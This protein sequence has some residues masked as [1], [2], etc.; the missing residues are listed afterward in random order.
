MYREGKRV[1]TPFVRISG[2]DI[3][4]IVESYRRVPRI[5]DQAGMDDGVT[6]GR[7]YLGNCACPAEEPGGHIRT[8]SD[9][10]SPVR[11]RAHARHA[12]K[13]GE[14]FFV[15]PPEIP[16]GGIHLPEP[17]L[18]KGYFHD[19]EP[20]G[21]KPAGY[22]KPCPGAVS[23][24]DWPDHRIVAACDDR[25]PVEGGK[26]VEGGEPYLGEGEEPVDAGEEVGENKVFVLEGH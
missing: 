15:L 20:T 11:F 3:E 16:D 19:P 26:S 21:G 1:G 18:G 12:D 2:L 4:V 9:I 22:D 13:E 24:K 5:G 14:I 25:C 6:H 23:G 10:R 7:N 17:G 8:P